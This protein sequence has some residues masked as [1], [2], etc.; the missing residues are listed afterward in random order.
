MAFLPFCQT[1]TAACSFTFIIQPCAGFFPLIIFSS[2]LCMGLSWCTER[3][4]K[5]NFLWM[6]FDPCIVCKFVGLSHLHSTGSKEVMRGS[7]GGRVCV[8]G[9]NYTLNGPYFSLLSGN[10]I[11]LKPLSGDKLHPM[12]IFCHNS[13]SNTKTCGLDICWDSCIFVIHAS[14]QPI[15]PQF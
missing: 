14:P 12:S 15:W 11:L 2:F 13:S 10:F 3:L 5:R 4:I 7:G 1:T 9:K 8:C 6:N